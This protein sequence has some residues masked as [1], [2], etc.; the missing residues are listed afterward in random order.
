MADSKPDTRYVVLVDVVD[1]REIPN[2]ERFE[3]QLEDALGFVNQTESENVST[4]FT[5][6]KGID[7]FGCVLRKLS[8]IPDIIPEVLNRIYPAYAR[9][10]VASGEI[11]IG[12]GRET[13]AQMDGPAFHRASELLESVEATDLYV[14]VKTNQ[15]TDALVANALNLLLLEREHL[16]SRQVETILAY[17][18]HGTQSKAGAEL[19][20]R[21]QAVSDTLHRA[22]YKR[23]KKIRRSLRD[24]IEKLYD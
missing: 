7:E 22:N 16:T 9:F 4:P 10:A 2:R 5:Q 24:T 11:D 20:L 1:S 18:K 14:D 23:R 15:K 6:M 21:Q 8:P 12:T 13:V 19:G 17:E 3:E